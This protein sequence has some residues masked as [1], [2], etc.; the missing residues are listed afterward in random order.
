MVYNDMFRESVSNPNPNPNPNQERQFAP[1][2][3]CRILVGRKA[4]ALILSRTPTLT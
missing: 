2:Y 1:L 3:L 4:L